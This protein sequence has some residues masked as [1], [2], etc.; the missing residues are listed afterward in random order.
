MVWR[1][2][3][4]L[5]VTVALAC[6]TLVC[7]G[8]TA[9]AQPRSPGT[10][11]AVFWSSEDD[12]ANQ[13]HDA[14]IREGLRSRPEAPIDYHAEYLESDRF[15]EEEASLAFRDYLDRKYRDRRIDV[16]IA[17]TD[18][19]LEFMLRYRGEL[20]PDAPIVFFGSKAVDPN[21][22]HDGAGLT[23]IVVSGVYRQTLQVALALHP[24]TERTFVVVQ[25]PDAAQQRLVQSTIGEISP[26]ATTF[27]VEESLPRLIAAVAAVPPRSVIVYVQYTQEVP[28]RSLLSSE[29]ARLVSTASPVPVYGVSDSDIGSGV[30]G[31]V[32]FVTRAIGVRL[33]EM[34]RQ[35]LDGAR[36]QDIP[37]ESAT[38]V[39]TFDW[40][41]LQRWGIGESWLP[42]GSRILHK[43]SGVWDLYRPQIMVGGLLVLVQSVLIG[44]LLVQRTRRRRV[45]RS[46]R[47]SEER[48]RLMADTA[49]VL[50]WR[51]GPDKLCDFVNRP[52][53]EFTGRTLEQE[54]G[55]DWLEGIYPEDVDSCRQTYVSA[56][57]AR[58]PFQMEYRL[59]RADGVYRWLLD[60]GV[61]RYGPDGNFAGYIGSALD[62]TDRKVSEDALRESQQRYTM[63]SA[64]GA[65]GVWDWNFETNQ[66]FVD[67][68]LKSLLG[69]EDAEISTRPDDWGSRVHP[70]DLPAAAT[71]VKAVID[72]DTDIYE[73]EHRMLHKDGSSR[74]FLSRGSAVRGVDG[75]LHRLVGTKVDITERRRAEERIRDNETA[76]QAS[77]AEIQRLAGSL[78][79]AQDTERAR[80]AR[81]L[82]DDVSQQL[83]ALSI[84]LS[85]LRRRVGA[86]SY[87]VDL[88][89]SMASIQ[90]RV[91]ALADSVRGLSHGLHP[92]VLKHAG[93][94]GTLATHCA[95]ISRQ[96]AITVTCS[97]EGDVVSIDLGSA[98]CLYRI[99]QE[100]LH[101]VVKH[102]QARHAEIRVL[103]TDESAELTVTDDG[104]GFDLGKTRRGGKGL[105]LV[106]ISERVRIAGGTLTLV[107]ECEKGTQLR[108]RL[109]LSSHEPEVGDVPGWYQST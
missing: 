24:L 12:P 82:H 7:T 79:A 11:L 49:P 85:S 29:V 61:P 104:Q 83:A 40:R 54:L 64:A 10:V 90:Q 39:P 38:P 55:N 59:R 26:A 13:V 88:H 99:A 86:V 42:V 37:I 76:L 87:D 22:S 70:E 93:L 95:G 89:D 34:A 48:F 92:D 75:T 25:T 73:I 33:G 51:A 6:L 43:Q 17:V 28:G 100:A 23:G 14:G 8:P 71:A 67:T 96:H 47:E 57:D 65:V 46:L 68:G 91:A 63:A 15:P 27:I 58:E 80:I 30:V 36:A 106:N 3:P 2:C 35:T 101:N 60:K 16:V 50:V 1:P 31:G 77:Y 9:W 84:T 4:R 97:A 62:I 109:P 103:C 102:A 19:A 32:V 44:A 56:F 5:L 69:F 81:D 45:E 52:W 108:V 21:S 105:G 107:T 98:L 41:Q 94:M 20:F 66:L 53:L 18:V 78:I 74:W 72:G